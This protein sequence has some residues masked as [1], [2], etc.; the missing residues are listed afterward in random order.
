MWGERVT[1]KSWL[2]VQRMRLPSSKM[3]MGKEQVWEMVGIQDGPVEQD[4]SR[5]SHGGDFEGQ[6]NPVSGTL[7]RLWAKDRDHQGKHSQGSSP[8]SGQDFQ[9]GV[10]LGRET[11]ELVA[12]PEVPGQTLPE[13]YEED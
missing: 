5:A 7:G 3:G 11:E 12:S 9:G 4:S 1:P 8:E 10:E 6:L 2:R 13:W